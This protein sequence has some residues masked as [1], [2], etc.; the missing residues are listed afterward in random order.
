MKLLENPVIYVAVQR[1]TGAA[2]T[3]RLL[4]PHFARFAGGS[5]VD[6]GSARG[7]ARTSEPSQTT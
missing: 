4:A 5:V 2:K 1:A 6:V 3:R 7:P